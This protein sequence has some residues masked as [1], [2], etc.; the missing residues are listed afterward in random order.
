ME[1]TTFMLLATIVSAA[2]ALLFAIIGV[3]TPGWPSTNT[4]LFDCSGC[5]Y[6]STA[7]GV[8]LI[9]AII[10][11]FIAGVVAILFLQRI[12]QRSLDLIKLLVLVLLLISGIF[13][14]AAYS[15]V[16]HIKGTNVYSY[17]LAVTAGV[18]TF[19]SALFFSYFMGRT[20][21]YIREQ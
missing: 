17:H 20:S 21:V 8:L 7:I 14:V 5:P 2:L 4:R 6:N 1:Q 18:L 15:T 10:F 13:I 11:L 19:L 12:L 3:A 9:I 16:F